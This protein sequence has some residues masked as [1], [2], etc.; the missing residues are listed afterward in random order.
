M[1][2]LFELARLCTSNEANKTPAIA[3]QIML[4]DIVLD[5]QPACC[6]VIVVGHADFHPL[7]IPVA[8]A[9]RIHVAM[10]V[11]VLSFIFRLSFCFGL[12]LGLCLRLGSGLG[13]LL[14]FTFCSCLL[15]LCFTFGFC[16]RSPYVVLRLV[17]IDHLRVRVLKY[18]GKCFAYH[19]IA[20]PEP[21]GI[22]LDRSK[23]TLKQPE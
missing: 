23:S 5:A 15:L 20:A 17:P 12:G 22:E 3:R 14:C 16:F 8:V 21:L 7:N 13:L 9:K 4:L 1:Q 2:S 6:L 19:A 11:L 10:L 18:V